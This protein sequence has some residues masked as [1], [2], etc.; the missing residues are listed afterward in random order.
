MLMDYFLYV[1]SSQSI[2]QPKNEIIG[3]DLSEV[4]MIP[5]FVYNSFQFSIQ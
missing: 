5:F 3:V 4:G 2:P 1:K